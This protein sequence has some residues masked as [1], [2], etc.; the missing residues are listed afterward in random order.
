[1]RRILHYSEAFY[2]MS[3][4]NLSYAGGGGGGGYPGQQGYPGVQQGGYPGS[5]Y[6]GAQQPVS[7]YPGSRPG[8]GYPGQ[9]Q[10]QQMAGYPGA[11]P[12]Q[13]AGFP[14]AQMGGYPGVA[15]GVSPEVQQWFAAVD[16]DRSGRISGKELQ[17][18]LING[19]GK[20]FSDTACLLMIGMFDRDRSGTIDVNEFQQLYN[21]IN[22]WLATFRTYDRDNSGH[23]EEA[24]LSQ[25]LQQMGFRFSPEF[26]KFLVTKSDLQHHKHISVDQFVVICVQIQRFTE[27]FRARD[28]EL[29]GVIT[30]SFE[31]FLGVALSCSV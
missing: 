4:Q 2:I 1:M 29:K 14:G 21:Y 13:M 12:Q 8:S 24:E 15:P 18:A 3:Y 23:I 19:Q 17:G 25:A 26:V 20:N 9:P 7:G 22:Q 6:P 11:Q 30:I 31:D 16:R 10:P 28:K 5:G 27:A